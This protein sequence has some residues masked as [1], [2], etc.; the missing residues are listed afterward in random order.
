MR[1]QRSIQPNRKARRA[2]EA[3]GIDPTDLTDEQ[4]EQL[5][6][7]LLADYLLPAQL[8]GELGLC[9]E[10]LKRWRRL[11]RG[12]PVT[13]IGRRVFYHRAGVIAW[14]RSQEVPSYEGAVSNA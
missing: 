9:L 12:P 14:M 8:A 10:T 4:V 2:A 5:N 7:P 13:K 1:P 3:K 11:S 6:Q